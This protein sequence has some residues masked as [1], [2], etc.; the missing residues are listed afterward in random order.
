MYAHSRNVIDRTFMSSSARAC[1]GSEIRSD[2]RWWGSL[3]GAEQRGRQGALAAAV[4]RL[5]GNL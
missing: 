5:S 4:G 3:I 2:E 1:S